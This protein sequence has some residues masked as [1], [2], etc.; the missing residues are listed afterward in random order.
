MKQKWGREGYAGHW[1]SDRRVW[2]IA[3]FFVA[4]LSVVAIYAYHYEPVW[5]PLQRFYLGH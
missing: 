5:T 2:T 4:L 1:P 3:A